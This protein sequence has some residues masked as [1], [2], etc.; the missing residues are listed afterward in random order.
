M[1]KLEINRQDLEHN[2]KVIKERA[3]DT[4][5][6]AVLKGNGYG[7]DIQQFPELL[8]N[9]G[10]NYLAV[11]SVEE[12]L[13]LADT[14]YEAMIL[15]MQQTPFEEDLEK[16]LDRNIIITVGNV[17]TARTLNKIAI[18]RK[19]KAHVHLKID[20]G[21][22]RYGF[23]YSDITT[24]LNTIKEC[25]SLFIDGIFTQFSCA[26]FKKDTFTRLQY[27][28]FLEVKEFLERNHIKIPMYHISNSSAFLQYDDMFLDAVRIGSAFT[29]RL[30]VEN[31]I[32]L[33]KI[34]RLKTTVVGIKELEKNTP[35]GYSN[36]EITKK[37][38]TIAIVP[39]GYADGVNVGVQNDTFKFR[40]KVRILKHSLESFFKDDRIYAYVNEK[41]YPVIGRLG[42]NH[43]AIDVTGEKISLGQEVI[44]EVSPVLVDSKIRR[45]YV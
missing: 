25:T 8:L 23:I 18:E 6:I 41:K 7:L 36:S 44:F 9:A 30:Q 37:P 28:R 20:T 5:I 34:G 2:I 26:Y 42:M 11:S 31:K 39:V 40:D 14:K 13:E 45:E 24:I 35:V 15:C 4:R 16:M 22:E 17:E 33:R 1:K 32:G 21:F 12:A 38:T 43:I 3:G 27:K 19:K 10:I 29:G